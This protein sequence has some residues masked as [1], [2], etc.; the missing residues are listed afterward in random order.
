MSRSRNYNFQR[1]QKGMTLIELVV[2]IVV[3]LI[4][5]SFAVAGISGVMSKSDVSGEAQGLA[6][7]IANT[8]SARANGTY[9]ASGTNLVPTLIAMRAIPA[10]VA[11][12]GTTLTNQWGGAIGVLS[13]GAGYSVSTAAIPP[14]ACIELATK[15]SRSMV[16]TTINGGTP[17]VG[18]VATA[19]A[20]TG[21]AN[22]GNANTVLWTAAS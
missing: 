12:N 10:S 18:P 17:I 14:E 2:A 16:S 9:G 6:G 22:D 5:I 13:T 4:I 20:T 19:A 15:L 21:C 3:G 7:L 1:R 11:V 8:K